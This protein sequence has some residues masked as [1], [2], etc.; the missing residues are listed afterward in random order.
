VKI[1]QSEFFIKP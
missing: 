1:T